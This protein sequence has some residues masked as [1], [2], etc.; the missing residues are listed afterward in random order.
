M[1]RTPN[2]GTGKSGGDD[3]LNFR[4]RL[5][6]H[7]FHADQHHR[8][9]QRLR[10]VGQELAQ[11]TVMRMRMTGSVGRFALC[12]ALCFR[13]LSGSIGF[14]M[15]SVMMDVSARAGRG[16]FALPCPLG[17]LMTACR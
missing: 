10:G 6:D 13:T 17:V 1:R 2:I 12:G 4:D 16:D 11:L 5:F 15:L 7:L 3:G 8:A 14:R 9:A